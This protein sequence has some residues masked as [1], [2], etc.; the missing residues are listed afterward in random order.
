MPRA[1]EPPRKFSYA[2]T[3]SFL[4]FTLIKRCA[5]SPL[6]VCFTFVVVIVVVG[7]VVIVRKLAR[8]SGK[9]H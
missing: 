5:L 8:T 9:K 6:G 2:R 1:R 3:G 4:L 7:V